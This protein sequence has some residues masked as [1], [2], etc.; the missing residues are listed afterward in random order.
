MDLTNQY[1]IDGSIHEDSLHQ[2]LK[3]S[4]TSSLVQLVQH[5]LKSN[6]MWTLLDLPELKIQDVRMNWLGGLRRRV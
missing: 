4:E 3:T 5:E 2:G 1:R 6:S